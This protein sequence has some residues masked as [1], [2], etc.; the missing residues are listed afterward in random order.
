MVDFILVGPLTNFAMCIIM[1]GA[2]FLDNVGEVYI[3]GGNYRGKGNTTKSAEFNFM[4]DPEAAH[5][6]L[7]NVKT[8]VTILPWETC[9][10]Q[11]FRITLVSIYILFYIILSYFF[12]FFNGFIILFIFCYYL[13]LF[14]KYFIVF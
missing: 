10:D 8:P 3:M 14:A 6:V 12:K 4:M 2:K 5:I 1:Y 13:F 9:D 7:D 11:A